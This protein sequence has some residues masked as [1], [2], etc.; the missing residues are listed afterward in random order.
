MA[1]NYK[2]YQEF[3]NK[4]LEKEINLVRKIQNASKPNKEI[5]HKLKEN[6][7][8]IKEKIFLNKSNIIKTYRNIELT[9]LLQSEDSKSIYYSTDKSLTVPDNIVNEEREKFCREKFKLSV[10][11]LKY[12]LEKNIADI[13]MLYNNL[14]N[15][16]KLTNDD[17]NSL[18]NSMKSIEQ[19]IND[20]E[21]EYFISKKKLKE[22]ISNLY[23]F[24]E[25]E[26]ES[27]VN[28]FNTNLLDL[29]SSISKTLNTE[30][31]ILEQNIKSEIT[32]INLQFS[33]KNNSNNDL[34][35]FSNEYEKIFN[36]KND[37]LSKNLLFL[38][39]FLESISSEKDYLFIKTLNPSNLLIN[40][41]TSYENLIELIKTQIE[42]T[43]ELRKKIYSK[44]IDL[45]KTEL[46]IQWLVIIDKVYDTQ[47]NALSDISNLSTNRIEEVNSKSSE[48]IN[49]FLENTLRQFDIKINYDEI[50]DDGEHNK[51]YEL[52]K[53]LLR[54]QFEFDWNLKEFYDTSR[55]IMRKEAVILIFSKFGYL[56]K[57]IDYFQKEI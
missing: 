41:D 20:I 8:A 6:L 52:E 14:K 51:L 17:I 56:E 48:L 13:E 30:R 27:K 39:T 38:N 34:I 55:E 36:L 9:K 43:I 22:L 26:L 25:L 45:L 35:S 21:K 16:K 1:I 37:Y 31:S 47:L 50:N 29:K 49:N 4:E 32:A 46:E 11:I 33:N 53:S 10:P 15:V 7:E 18:T 24:K 40:D 5:I 57:K 12:G 54:E 44:K 2:V 42:I 23:I 19:N 3:N 28:N